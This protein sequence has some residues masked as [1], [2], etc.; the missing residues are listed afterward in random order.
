MLL[1]RFG[2][3][4]QSPL[5]QNRYPVSQTRRSA[6][7]TCRTKQCPSEN[8]PSRT[9][10][11]IIDRRYAGLFRRPREPAVMKNRPGRELVNIGFLGP[12]KQLRIA[13]WTSDAPWRA[14]RTRPSQCQGGY[15]ATGATRAKPYE[16]RVHYDSAQWGASSTEAVKMIFN[17][18]VVGVLGLRRWRV[19]AHH[20]ARCLE[21]GIS[22]HR[23]RHNRS[24]RNR[25]THSLADSQFSG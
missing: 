9:K 23:Y 20:V 12:S 16:L 4:A 10:S 5:P 14:T 1:L 6:T 3:T 15:R 7:R 18:H 11:G 21:T 24:H 8:S 13:L 2:H 17:E 22:H 19:H 25:N